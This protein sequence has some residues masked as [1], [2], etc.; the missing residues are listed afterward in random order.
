M[1]ATTCRTTRRKTYWP[2]SLRQRRGSPEGSTGI[3]C[4]APRFLATVADEIDWMIERVI[5]R[6]ANGMISAIPRPERA[7]LRQTWRLLWHWES[8]GWASAFRAR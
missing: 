7:G 4:P 3:V 5:Q 6:G 2:R 8:L 1:S